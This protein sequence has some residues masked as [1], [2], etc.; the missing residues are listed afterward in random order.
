L[1]REETSEVNQLLTMSTRELTRLDLMRRL[2]DGRLTQREAAAALHLSTRQVKRLWKAY[3]REG[4]RALVSR[5][6]GRPSNRRLDPALTARA[7]ELIRA[8]YHDFGPTLAHEKLLEVHGLRLSVETLR[9]LMIGAGLWRARRARRPSPHQMR[10]RRPCLGE[11]VQLDGSPHAW[12]EGRAAKCTL[13]VFIDDATGRLMQLLFV[14]AE[15]TF[16]YFAAVRAYLTAHGKPAAFY[17]D[18]LGVFRVNQPCLSPG[19][20]GLTQFGRAMRE[21]DIALICANTPQAKGR[22]ERANQ[23]LQDRLVKELRLRSISDMDAANAYAPEFVADFNHRF[24]VAPACAHDAHRPLQPGEELGR[25]L[26]LVE[27]RTL[28]KNLTF[29]YKKKI[30]QVSTSRPTYAMRG[31]RV[32]VR[33]DS[34]GAVSVEYKGRALD[35]TTLAAQP[36]RAEAL[37]TKLLD[38]AL[39]LVARESQAPR[40]GRSRHPPPHHPWRKFNYGSNAPP[41]QY[42]RDTSKWRT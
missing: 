10:S 35:Y 27:G 30:Y 28:S 1:I 4:E 34:E 25:I 16:N 37:P 40:P 22:V 8:L 26:S 17:S 7:L 19:S 13:L 18:K 31:A 5:R 24:G 6:R 15:T 39:D 14:A 2:R 33:E 12:F 38:A 32:E 20:T 42:R 23:T 29:S 41:T 11:L 9:Q 36:H 3:Q 21:L